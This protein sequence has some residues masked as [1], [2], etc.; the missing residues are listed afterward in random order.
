MVFGQ[1]VKS[2]RPYFKK[3]YK[4]NK[5][6]VKGL[7][8]KDIKF[9]VKMGDI[10]KIEEKHCIGISVFGY[11]NNE[12][13]PIYVSKICCEKKTCWLII[14]RGRNKKHY[15]LINDFNRFVYDH[16]LYC[17][18]KHFCRY[19]LQ[20]FI[21]EEILKSHI[22]SCFKINGKQTFTM[23]KKMNMLNLKILKEK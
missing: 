4:A 11:E 3:I 2:C 6:F 13:Y 10:H 1:I 21:R 19:C 15:V 14:D 12:K 8:F 5:D 7:D 16:T 22:E 23:F 9:P 20:A 18:R 17:R